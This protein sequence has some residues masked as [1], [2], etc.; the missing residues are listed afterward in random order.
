MVN[1]ALRLKSL[2]TPSLTQDALGKRIPRGLE[3]AL[4]MKTWS[5]NVRLDTPRYIYN[6]WMPSLDRSFNSI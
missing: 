5:A 2:P 4:E 1:A 3:L 6:S